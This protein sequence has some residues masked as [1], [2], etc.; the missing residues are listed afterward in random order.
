MPHRRNSG[1]AGLRSLLG[2][3]APERIVDLQ[4]NLTTRIATLGMTVRG[5]FSLQ[6]GLRKKILAGG[7]GTMPS[8]RLEYL[9]AAGFSSGD[10]PVLSRN[11]PGPDRL[12]V[13]IAAGSRW[14]LKSI[15]EGVI[16]EAARLFID[17]HGA[18][19]VITG[20]PGEEGT[21]AGVAA[22][23]MRGGVSTYCG[24]DGIEGLMRV[25]E[26]LSLLV[27][28]DSGPAHLAA[29][30]GVP[31]MV[32]FTSTSPALGFW[33]DGYASFFSSGSLECRPCHRH[34]GQV[35]RR[36]DEECRRSIVP[37]ELVDSAMGIMDR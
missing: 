4:N 25:I 11:G 30:L 20:G 15:P 19:V 24:E 10:M 5:R 9:R 22:S 33:E 7:G 2:E 27:S 13:G 6:R 21:V 26:G 18:E 17:L 3:L 36:G 29:A 31:V 32:V 14:R 1:A 28:P 34:G 16:A 37:L 23:V 35:C 12:T 8:R